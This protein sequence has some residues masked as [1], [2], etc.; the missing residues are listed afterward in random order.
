MSLVQR[1]WQTPEGSPTSQGDSD[2]AIIRH[3]C[4][5]ALRYSGWPRGSN[6]GQEE[7]ESR[8]TT[9][10]R[11]TSSGPNTSE[12]ERSAG[13]RC[14]PGRD[15]RVR[16]SAPEG[17]YH[18]LAMVS[19]PAKQR[20]SSLPYKPGSYYKVIGSFCSYQHWKGICQA[21]TKLRSVFFGNEYCGVQTSLLGKD[22][23][24]NNEYCRCY[25]T[26]K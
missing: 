24:L 21:V 2:V 18:G 6:Y 23:E 25:A 17:S 20:S 4:Q 9:L 19:A 10:Q 3:F 7:E 22:L 15:R 5:N 26:G 14:V 11:L 12:E 8:Q 13:R 16:K 1:Q